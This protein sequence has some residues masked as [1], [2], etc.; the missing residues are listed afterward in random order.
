MNAAFPSFLAFVSFFSGFGFS[1]LTGEMGGRMGGPWGRSTSSTSSSPSF[2][3]QSLSYRLWFRL[4][5]SAAEQLLYPPTIQCVCTSLWKSFQRFICLA[6]WQR[7]S[8]S[9]SLLVF[10]LNGFNWFLILWPWWTHFTLD[11]PPSRLLS[12]GWFSKRNQTILY[13][14]RLQY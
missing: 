9:I 4:L 6:P 8:T 5:H 2:S 1:S 13:L 7:H 12:W 3:L 14:N 11:Y 10:L